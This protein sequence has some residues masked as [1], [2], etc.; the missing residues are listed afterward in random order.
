MVVN[1]FINSEYFYYAKNCLECTEKQRRQKWEG[2]HNISKISESN[3]VLRALKQIYLEPILAAPCTLHFQAMK[4]LQVFKTSHFQEFSIKC[5]PNMQTWRCILAPKWELHSVQSMFWVDAE[6][7]ATYKEP[8][9]GPHM[10]TWLFWHKTTAHSC[11]PLGVNCA[12]VRVTLTHYSRQYSG[13][14]A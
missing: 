2:S 13:C 10:K 9:E 14:L 1:I 4:F 7:K 8:V 11:L 3:E 5:A 6:G 12:A